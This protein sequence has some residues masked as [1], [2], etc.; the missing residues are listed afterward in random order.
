MRGL[1]HIE[2]CKE[3]LCEAC[4]KGKS[5]K[6]SDGSKDMTNIS[7]TLQL[8]HM[9]LFGPEN[10]MSMSRKRFALVMVDDYSKY[11]W[12][13][14]LHL[15][16]ETPQL[17]I[18]HVKKIELEANLLVRM[19]RSDN[20]TVFKNFVLNDFC[21]DK[22]ISRQFLAPRTLQENGVVERKNRTL[23]EAARTMLSESRLPM[24]LWAKVVNTACY[25]QNRTLI[26]KE[27][28]NTPYEIIS[29]KKPTLK[30]FHVF[31]G[32]CFVLKY[33]EHLGKFEAK[34]SEGIF[35]GYSLES[36]AFRVYMIDHKKVIECL[37]VTFDDYKLP[38]IQTEDSTKTLKVQNMHDSEPDSDLDESVVVDGNND[39]GGDDPNIGD[40]DN[41]STLQDYTTS[42]ST[43][44]EERS[45]SHSSSSSGGAD[46]GSTSHTQQNERR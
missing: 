8:I 24:Y 25:T 39:T 26:T 12:V 19:I 40:E 2:F 11:T 4:K 5:K 3:G 18:D 6:A 46:Q 44:H 27:H 16:D 20:G 21:I 41:S 32:K 28:E 35:L 17:I 29:N 38:S 30:Y 36:K 43:S 37:N 33:D 13:L 31:G 42:Y 34:A 23:I 1:P 14:F 10:V 15:K 22:G 9:D 7:E 45:S